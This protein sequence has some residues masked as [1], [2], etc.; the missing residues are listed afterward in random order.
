MDPRLAG[1]RKRLAGIDR[2][3]A[4]TGGKGGI[5]KSVVSV[6]LS[7][8]LAESG[9]RT[10]L[11]DLDLTGPTDHVL[12]GLDF[13]E[14]FP[15]EEFGV[16]P[17]LVGGVRF[18]SIACFSKQSPAALRGRDVTNALIE[19]LAIT[20]WDELDVLVLDMPPGLGDTS[21]DIVRL[22]ERAEHLVLATSSRVVLE[23]VRRTLDVLAQL[24]TRVLGVLENMKSDSSQAVE[25]LASR[26]SVPYLG[27]LPED[28]SLE[29][30]TGTAESLVRTPT[31]RA[32]REVISA[33]F[34]QVR[35][36]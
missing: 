28:S 20:R 25:Q 29:L 22:L 1:V 30:A 6:S 35:G 21:L 9:L 2:I 27:S 26:F 23:T 11:L 36:S 8:L 17:M 14:Q 34:P 15:S 5:G 18:M 7:L 4:V 32:L 24:R 33:V 3:I 19:M 10:G 12:L 13:G 31:A 16:D